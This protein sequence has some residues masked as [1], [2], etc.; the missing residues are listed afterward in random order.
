MWLGRRLGEV[1]LERGLG[2][3]P[4]GSD[5]NA[6]AHQYVNRSVG[7]C[8]ARSDPCRCSFDEASLWYGVGWLAGFG[9]DR[10]GTNPASR[11]RPRRLPAFWHAGDDK[12]F[13]AVSGKRSRPARRNPA[14][15]DDALGEGVDRWLDWASPERE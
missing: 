4:A 9:E 15:R 11:M 3:E 6:R 2:D 8:R 7:G 13:G 5:R 12:R 10:G 1:A 14:A